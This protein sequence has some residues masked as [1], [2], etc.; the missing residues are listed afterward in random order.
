ME[1][2]MKRKL[3]SEAKFDARLCPRLCSCSDSPPPPDYG[4][5]ANAS[6][7]A[8][9]L[10]TEQADRVLAENKRQ[11]DLNMA[12]AKPVID[13]QLRMMAEAQR[14][15]EDYYDYMVRNQRPVE[16]A[17]NAD[18]M[19][20]GT[21]AKI[22]E[23]VAAAV[24]DSQNGYTRSLNQAIRQARRYGIDSIAPVG[25]QIIQQAQNT[26]AAANEAR[27]REEALGY[28]KKLDVAGLYR[29]L[30]GASQGAYSI[31]AQTGDSAVR[32]QVAP[33]AQYMNGNVVGADI[34]R[35]GQALKM[36]GLGNILSAQANIAARDNDNG[37]FGALG[38]IGG[39]LIGKI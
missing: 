27:R 34:A 6:E 20:A 8:A 35:Q 37:L 26:A 21:P 18:A 1:T 31:A 25:S 33:S 32:N 12:V 15:G 13:A 29:G 36:Q 10:A 24:A 5:M 39:A 14:Q 19:A 4:P 9:R 2:P 38:T 3:R 17:L 23:R 22:D 7:E 11:Y 28:A 16:A 30:P